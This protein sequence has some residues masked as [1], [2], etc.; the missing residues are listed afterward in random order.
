VLFFI[1]KEK[2]F[3]FWGKGVP[4]DADLS[5]TPFFFNYLACHL[6]A[7]YMI[8]GHMIVAFQVMISLILI[9]AYT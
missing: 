1:F 7:T 6:P 4:F 8:V 2:K 5:I 3:L 9:S